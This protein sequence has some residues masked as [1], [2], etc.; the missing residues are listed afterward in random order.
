M[1]ELVQRVDLIFGEYSDEKYK[2]LEETLSRSNEDIIHD[3]LNSGLKGRGGAGFPTAMKWKFAA[4]QP[5]KE[6]YVVCNADEGE[7]NL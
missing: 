7:P 3:L 4:E 5:V 6:K 2:V 1:A